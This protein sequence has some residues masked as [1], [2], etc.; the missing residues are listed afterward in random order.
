MLIK[1]KIQLLY[2]IGNILLTVA[3]VG[4]VV[5]HYVLQ[6]TIVTVMV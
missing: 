2:T 3:A 6:T 5:S 1:P 4:L